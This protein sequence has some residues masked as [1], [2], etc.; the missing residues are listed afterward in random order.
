MTVKLSSLRTDPNKRQDGEWIDI[1]D[2]PGVSFRVRGLTFKPYTVERDALVRRKLKSLNGKPWDNDERNAAF[3]ALYAKHILLEWK[4]LDEPYS[5]DT[6]SD[7]LTDP[8]YWENFGAYVEWAAGRVGGAQV[9]FEDDAAGN[10][11]KS[12]ATA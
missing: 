6:A 8:A 10:S 12:S 4:G 3:G 2:L 1:P 5:P 9:E 7:C 11:G